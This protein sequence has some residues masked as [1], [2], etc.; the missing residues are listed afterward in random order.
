MLLEQE[1][2][3]VDEDDPLAKLEG[4]MRAIE[5]LLLEMPGL[6]PE[7]VNAAKEGVRANE[8]FRTRSTRSAELLEK[9]GAPLDKHA[10]AWLDN[11]A[12]SLKKRG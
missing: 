5:A 11:L 2:P 7:R 4:K 10:E 12:S 3:M 6:T 1:G 8:K 9:T